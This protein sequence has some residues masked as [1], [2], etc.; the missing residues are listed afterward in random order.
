MEQSGARRSSREAR[1]ENELQ[2]AYTDVFGCSED[3]S[4]MSILLGGKD[5]VI[6]RLEGWLREREERC[7]V[8]TERDGTLIVPRLESG[9]RWTLIQTD[10]PVGRLVLLA[11][12]VAC[13]PD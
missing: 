7:W 10:R 4:D 11:L 2:A 1:I 13:V 8:M 6:A 9:T 5:R 12:D 3:I